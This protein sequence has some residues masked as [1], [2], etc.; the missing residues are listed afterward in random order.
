MDNGCITGHAAPI[1]PVLHALQS[2]SDRCRLEAFF[3]SQLVQHFVVLTDRGLLLPIRLQGIAAST[4]V[5]LYLVQ[6]PLNAGQATH[7]LLA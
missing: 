3:L 7:E 2:G 6:T 4:T 1:G 5:F